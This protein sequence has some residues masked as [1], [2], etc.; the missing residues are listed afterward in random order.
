MTDGQ[1]AELDRP[2][3]ARIY[4]YLLGGDQNF[5]ADRAA[6]EHVLDNYPDAALAARANRAFLRRAV[7]A[8]AQEGID[9]FLD[10]GSGLP[11]VGNVHEVARGINPK[12]GVVYVDNDPVAVRYSREILAEEGEGGRTVAAIE[13]DLR[14]P[15]AI[16]DHPVT[17]R[18]LDVRRPLG[19]LLVAVLHFVPDDDEAWRAMR[20]FREILVPGSYVVISHATLDGLPADVI[21]RFEAI[22]RR[23]TTPTIARPRARIEA[24]FEGLGV[25]EP[26]IVPTPRWRPDAA[27]APRRRAGAPT[28]RWRP[29]AALAPRRGARPARG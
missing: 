4:D 29:D 21:A 13:A 6:A 23:S 14:D 25:V 26:G 12:A 22:Y 17:R 18:L 24:L 3:A 10:I 1:G 7:T 8:L 27:L 2:N 20:T 5:T 11:T 16:L 19:L 28:P 15:A 9:Q